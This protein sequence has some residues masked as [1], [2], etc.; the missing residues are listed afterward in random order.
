MRPGHCDYICR[1]EGKGVVS[2]ARA[3][4]L[5]VA[6]EEMRQPGWIRPSAAD[7]GGHREEE[8]I[9]HSDT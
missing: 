6:A 2:Y 1:F 4:S 5:A 3:A 7:L 8:G 9:H